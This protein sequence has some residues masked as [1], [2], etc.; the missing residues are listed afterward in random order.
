MTNKERIQKTIKEDGLTIG[1]WDP[2]L[3]LLDD[4]GLATVLGHICEESDCEVSINNVRFIV[5]L[6]IVDGEVDFSL[7][8]L[9]EYEARY[10]AWEDEE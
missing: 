2:N 6:D 10:G 3:E 1:C 8:S 7:L 9:E 4:N 5:E